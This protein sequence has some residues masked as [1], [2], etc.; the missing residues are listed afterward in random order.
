MDGYEWSVDKYA[1]VYSSKIPEEQKQKTSVSLHMF[2][3]DSTLTEVR[4]ENILPG[5]AE[6]FASLKRTDKDL[7]I[8]ISNQRS[9]STD[10]KGDKESA[11]KIR[12][13]KIL[14]ETGLSKLNFFAAL[15]CAGPN[16]FR[17]PNSFIFSEI[18]LPM[19]AIKGVREISD[20]EY[21]GD[22]AGRDGDFD[23]VDRGLLYNISMLINNPAWKKANTAIKITNQP[24]FIEPE[25]YFNSE[26]PREFGWFKTGPKMFL[27]RAFKRL[28]VKKYSDITDEMRALPEIGDAQSVIFMVGPPASGKS[29]LTER[30]LALNPNCRSVSQEEQGTKA[31]ATKML[32]TYLEAGH[33]VIIDNTN[34]TNAQRKTYTDIAN[35]YFAKNKLPVHIAA[36]L[37]WADVGNDMKSLSMH[38]NAVRGRLIYHDTGESFLIP[39]VGINAYFSKFNKP[40]IGEGPLTEIVEIP[41]VP[42]FPTTWH[43]LYFMQVS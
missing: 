41:F 31:K 35:A 9:L 8:I 5:V 25:L 15:I 22:A 32:K 11:F 12:L 36:W 28:G 27:Q 2:D 40:T 29:T 6:K 26:E 24:K 14:T 20:M 43:A 19:L 34:G 17:K 18:L 42:H 37:I 1:L 23:D 21:I 38:M 39:T 7:F 4:S 3:L 13:E 10:D 16:V 30:V 33:T